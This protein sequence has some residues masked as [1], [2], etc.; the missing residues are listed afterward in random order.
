MHTPAVSLRLKRFRRR[1]GISAP[2]VVVRSEL[3]RQWLVGFGVLL[4]AIGF[5]AA[6]FIQSASFGGVQL[7]GL[8]DQLQVQQSELDLLRASVGTGQSAVSIERAAQQQLLARIQSL[9]AE[10]S[11]LKEDMLIFERLIPVIGQEAKVRIESFRISSNAGGSYRYRLLLAY[12]SA[13]RGAGFR[14]RYEVVVTYKTPGAQTRQIVLPDGR[15]GV[16]EVRH[17]LRR[18]GMIELPSGAVLVSAEVRLLQ[19][20][21]L[22]TKEAAV[23]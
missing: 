17:F 8:K 10:N 19:D 14:G 5:A 12:Q 11:A 23:I 3:P 18:E 22:V 2:R 21:K 9:E 4:M 1:F 7:A 16:V 6:W 20:G 15:G 13:Q